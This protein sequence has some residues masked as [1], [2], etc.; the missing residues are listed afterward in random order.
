[1]KDAINQEIVEIDKICDSKENGEHDITILLPKEPTFSLKDQMQ[2][3]DDLLGEENTKGNI[4]KSTKEKINL[5]VKG[6]LKKVHRSHELEKLKLKEEQQ[7]EFSNVLKELANE[8]TAKVQESVKDLRHLQDTNKLEDRSPM[9]AEIKATKDRGTSTDDLH[10]TRNDKTSMSSLDMVDEL[11]RENEGLRRSFDELE[12]VFTKDKKELTEKLQTQ[13]LDFVMSAEGEIIEKLLKQKLSL[14]EALNTERFYLSRLYYQE[15]KDE[16]GDILSRRTEKLKREFNGEKMNLIFKYERDIT[17][18]QKLL[19]E[20]AELEMRL[21]QERNDVTAKLLAAHKN[22]SPE[23]SKRA[24]LKEK[25][26][27]ERDKENLEIAIPLKK[28]IAA[29][30]NKRHQEHEKA[31]ANLKEAIDLIMDV[32]A[33][34]PLTTPEDVKPFDSLSFLSQDTARSNEVSPAGKVNENG[35]K[36]RTQAS[37]SQNEIHNRD[38]LGKALEK[39]VDT[40]VSEDEEFTYESE[41]TSGASSDL[42]SEDSGTGALNGDIDEGAYSGPESNDDENTLNIKKKELEFT[43]NLERFNLGRL[44]YGE[45]KD[46]LRKAMKKLEQ[47]KEALRSKRKDLEKE[48]RNGI[49][50]V[51]SRTHFGEVSTQASKR[52]KVT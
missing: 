10:Q 32:M 47:A 49:E 6:L 25:E 17:D 28:E 33:S 9:C 39:L 4:D 40:V 42:E 24:R 46:S 1:M 15:M 45:Y 19:S 27:L 22:A 50:L 34:A 8:K 48:M 44:Y 11:R 31:A 51:V 2:A 26:R 21:L 13:H 29:L 52:D 20:K 37:L 23:K 3:V 38:E 18:L 5:Q 35:F 36:T 7:H 12:N 41:A 14:E 43:F 30:Q 16:L